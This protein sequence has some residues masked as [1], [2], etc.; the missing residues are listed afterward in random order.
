MRHLCNCIY[1]FRKEFVQYI[2]NGVTKRIFSSL[3]PSLSL[4][5]CVIF[6]PFDSWSEFFSVYRREQNSRKPQ[7]KGKINILGWTDVVCRS[8]PVFCE[9]WRVCR[10][11]ESEKNPESTSKQS[12]PHKKNN[13]L[14]IEWNCP[15][16]ACK[17]KSGVRQG[18]FSTAF[19]ISSLHIWPTYH[20]LLL[21]LLKINSFWANP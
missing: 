20:H 4:T 18:S 15:F 2:V 6:I 7:T 19:T 5:H 3:P 13:W 21:K 8:E 17:D 1:K 11:K 9:T 12:G 10:W 14:F 16:R